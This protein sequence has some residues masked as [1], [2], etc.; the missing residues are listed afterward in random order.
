[1]AGGKKKS[2]QGKKSELPKGSL[3]KRDR[4]AHVGAAPKAIALVE[5]APAPRP[6]AAGEP[7]VAQRRGA[8]TEMVPVRFDAPTLAEVKQAAADDHRS[9]SSWIRRAVDLELQRGRV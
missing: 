5:A 6:P 9:V 4:E 2:K 3:P 8:L 1:M 7:G